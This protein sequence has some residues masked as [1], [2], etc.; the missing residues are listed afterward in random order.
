MQKHSENGKVQMIR[1]KV[2]KNNNS[3]NKNK[4]K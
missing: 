2:I 1:I 4:N 3:N